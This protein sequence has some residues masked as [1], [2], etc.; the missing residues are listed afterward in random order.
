MHFWNA[1]AGDRLLWNILKG[2]TTFSVLLVSKIR[3]T[4]RH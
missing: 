1:D 2:E 4:G 3:L